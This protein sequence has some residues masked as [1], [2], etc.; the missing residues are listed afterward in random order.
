MTTPQG[1]K[2]LLRDQG[3]ATVVEFA[4]AIPILITLMIGILQFA[5]VMHT[6]G[7]LR[8][9][10]GEGL[11]Y[12][13]I[14]PHAT[15]EQIDAKTRGALDGIDPGGITGIDYVRGK[16]NGADFGRLTIEYQATPVV[17]FIPDRVI[18]LKETRQAYLQN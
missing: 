13:K 17:P 14:N 2:S 4:F 12:A 11:R 8:H 16:S 18:A 7:G 3:G 10:V 9:A 5:I 6:S 15:L 1:M